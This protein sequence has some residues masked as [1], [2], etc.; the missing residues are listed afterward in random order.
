MIIRN[1][2]ED[3]VVLCGRFGPAANDRIFFVFSYIAYIYTARQGGLLH[4]TSYLLV[5][6]YVYE[7]LT[8]VIQSSMT[9]SFFLCLQSNNRIAGVKEVELIV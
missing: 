1:V 7:S 5:H 4:I 2:S 9:F 3:D 8:D 6:T